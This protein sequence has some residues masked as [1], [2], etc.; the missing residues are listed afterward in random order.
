MAKKIEVALENKEFCATLGFKEQASDYVR[1]VSGLGEIC[2][3]Q[4]ER[5]DEA[6]VGLM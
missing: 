6:I 1:C 5:W 2:R 3:K 4:K